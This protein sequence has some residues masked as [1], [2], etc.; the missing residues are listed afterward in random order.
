VAR[1]KALAAGVLL[2][3]E[4]GGRVTDFRGN[5]GMYLSFG[6]QAVTNIGGG[7]DARVLFFTSAN[8]GTFE[9]FDWSVGGN[10]DIKKPGNVGIDL[11]FEGI[12]LDRLIAGHRSELTVL[13]GFGI[14][15]GVGGGK[16]P[17]GEAGLSITHSW[18]LK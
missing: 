10:V 8:M 17:V 5:G 14:G 18:R 13:R 1:L 3:R 11:N 2:I 7:L 16:V 15:A 12:V 4:A 9:G 6:P